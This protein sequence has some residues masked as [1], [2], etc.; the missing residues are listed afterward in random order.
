MLN[1]IKM[2]MRINTLENENEM[3]KNT[4]KDKLYEAFMNK[5]TEPIENQ[6]LK[7]ENRRLRR[8]IKNLKEELKK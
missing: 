4:M 7:K 3:L 8:V 5:L 2:R 6:R 1:R